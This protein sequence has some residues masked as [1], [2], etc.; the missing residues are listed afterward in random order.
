MNRRLRTAIAVTGAAAVLAATSGAAHAGQVSRETFHGPFA[1]V[2]WSTST[3]TSVTTVGSLSST[4]AKG[5]THIGIDEVTQDYDANG[6]LLG[7]VE[8]RGETTVGTSFTIDT[9][10]L[11]SASSQAAIPVT[12][13]TFDANGTTTA[14]R[15]AGTL[16]Y[17]A[18]W[19]G[20]GPIQRLPFNGLTMGDGVLSFEH[21][22]GTIRDAAADVTIDGVSVDASAIQ[23]ADMGVGKDIFL[24]ICPN[25]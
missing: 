1:E 12:R 15:S 25:C 17:S 11:S 22:G 2:A 4:D 18:D 24:T 5:T 16:D 20:L 7:G 9:V 3:P 19:T 14:C 8:L 13:C 23:F 6:N 10:K 21:D